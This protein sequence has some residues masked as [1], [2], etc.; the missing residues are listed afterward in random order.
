MK[1]WQY[2]NHRC[3][4]RTFSSRQTSRSHV[5]KSKSC[6]SCHNSKKIL[7][8]VKLDDSHDDKNHVFGNSRSFMNNEEQQQYKRKDMI[9][10]KPK[11][12][13]RYLSEYKK[14]NCKKMSP[15]SVSTRNKDPT[16]VRRKISKISQTT[17]DTNKSTVVMEFSTIQKIVQL[18]DNNGE[19]S[20]AKVT[21]IPAQDIIEKNKNFDLNGINKFDDCVVDTTVDKISR[22]TIR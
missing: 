12:K 18:V 13:L 2:R 8:Q 10:P 1:M 15:T 16:I 3:C 14:R 11:S 4:A 17:D 19:V 6:S 7:P 21:V 5:R 9:E 20:T 22:S